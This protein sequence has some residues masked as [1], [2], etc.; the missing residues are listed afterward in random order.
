MN[1]LPS[2]S[3]ACPTRLELSDWIDGVSTAGTDLENHIA[4]CPACQD[5]INSYRRI[6]SAT[7]CLSLPDDDLAA[8]IK[9]T[10]SNL[11]QEPVLLTWNRP[12][13][14]Y[15]A[16]LVLIASVITALAIRFNG[17][18]PQSESMV[19]FEKN[20]WSGI[21]QTEGTVKVAAKTVIDKEKS[22]VPGS[23][24]DHSELTMANVAGELASGREETGN[25]S[26]RPTMIVPALVRH[27]WVV[28]DVKD[29]VE[30]LSKNLPR[31]ST[32][33]TVTLKRQNAV[34]QI[35]LA[36]D[37]LQALVDKFA[38]RGWSLLSPSVPQPGSG[39]ELLLTG[40]TVRYDVNL[41]SS[42]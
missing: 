14:H 9:M 23:L 37:K 38:A 6:D 32:C 40:K 3:K 1:E 10:C 28:N 25:Y 33:T 4:V 20:E 41:V 22:P 8:R 13:F 27:V 17:N 34:L 36:D 42:R 39:N 7:K 2:M 29:S 12:L 15:A 18:V 26:Y 24:I 21:N 19:A 31:E 5:V 35:Q 11:Q 16:A 30:F